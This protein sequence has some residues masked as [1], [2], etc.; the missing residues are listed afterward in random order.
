MAP[1]RAGA[2]RRGRSGKEADRQQPPRRRPAHPTHRRSACACGAASHPESAGRPAGGAGVGAVLKPTQIDSEGPAG[3]CKAKHRVWA[4][5]TRR[6]TCFP[7]GGGVRR[8]GGEDGGDAGG[9]QRAGDIRQARRPAGEAPRRRT[10]RRYAD[11]GGR[12]RHRR[13]HLDAAHTTARCHGAGLREICSVVD[14]PSRTTPTPCYL[15][16]GAPSP[17]CVLRTSWGAALQ[18]PVRPAPENG[19][20]LGRSCACVS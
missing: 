15:A 20:T 12:A 3:L 7:P 1:C 6:R 14:T 17:S 10:A 9:G 16:A 11:Q 5:A 13:V 2:A 19:V 8:R 4:A 18:P